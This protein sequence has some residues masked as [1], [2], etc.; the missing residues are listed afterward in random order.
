MCPLL[1]VPLLFPPA[2]SLTAALRI[3]TLRKPPIAHTDC[4]PGYAERAPDVERHEWSAM[5]LGLPVVDAIRHSPI[6]NAHVVRRFQ[7]DMAG[8]RFLVQS[9]FQLVFRVRVVG[10][11]SVSLRPETLD[12]VG[13]AQLSADEVVDFARVALGESGI[14]CSR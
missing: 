3:A 8:A 6:V 12:I 2:H 10:T 11:R 13:T 7:A 4:V 14:A 1:S 9:I 5:L